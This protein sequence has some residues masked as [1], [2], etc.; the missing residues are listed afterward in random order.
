M[1]PP[2]TLHRETCKLLLCRRSAVA[3]QLCVNELSED[4]VSCDR[5]FRQVTP[6]KRARAR[7]RTH[8][9]EGRG[10]CVKRRKVHFAEPR[11]GDASQVRPQV[12]L[13]GCDH[14]SR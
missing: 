9:L 5:R 10:A 7:A 4:N 11:Q 8:S 6:W 2:A 12:C 14:A 3:Q 13:R 1:N